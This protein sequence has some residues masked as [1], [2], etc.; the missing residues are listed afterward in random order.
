MSAQTLAEI[1]RSVAA[2]KGVEV[3]IIDCL[4]KASDSIDKAASIWRDYDVVLFAGSLYLIGEVRSILK[5][6]SYDPNR[7]LKYGNQ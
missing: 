5:N 2:D 3:N 6:N 4:D 1:V 7:T